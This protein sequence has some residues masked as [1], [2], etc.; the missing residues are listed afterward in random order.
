VR[1][2]P[3]EAFA[4]SPVKIEAEYTIPIEHHNAM[5]LHASVANWEGNKLTIY[6]KTQAWT[7]VCDYLR[8]Y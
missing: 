7:G 5:E 3:D 8:N 6:D 1:G 4:N 2:K